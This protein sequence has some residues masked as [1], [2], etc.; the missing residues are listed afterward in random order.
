M[1]TVPPTSIRVTGV[2][3]CWGCN[4]LYAAAAARPNPGICPACQSEH[5]IA[6]ESA[7]APSQTAFFTVPPPPT[8]NTWAVEWRWKPLKAV[9]RR[10]TRPPDGYCPDWA[11]PWERLTVYNIPRKATGLQIAARHRQANPWKSFRLRPVAWDP[12]PL[13]P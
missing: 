8:P 5:T 12:V 7:S 13:L 10:I 2:R 11:N 4:T 3:R 6:V 9:K 1:P